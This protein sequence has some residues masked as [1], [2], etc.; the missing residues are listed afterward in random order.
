VALTGHQTPR[1]DAL[2]GLVS[3]RSSTKWMAC[4]ISV[5][6]LC[7]SLHA[8]TPQATALTS[9]D[10]ITFTGSVREV[11]T[12]PS[13]LSSVPSATLVRS[14]LAPAEA[15]ATLDFAIALKMHN[16][17]ELQE[18]T[19]AGQTISLDEIASKYYPTPV[20][21]KKVVDWLTGQ[22]F[23]VKQPNKYNLSVFAS[24]QVAQIERA[25]GAKFGRIKYA[26]VEY[27]SALTSPSLPVSVAAPVLGINGLQPHLHPV[28][29]LIQVAASQG[30][31]KAISNQPPY[32]VAEIAKAYGASGLN[33]NGAGQKIGIVIDTFPTNSDLTMFW[34]ANAIVQSLNNIEKVQVVPGTLP[35]TSGEESLDVEWSSGTAP[36]AK[37]RVYATT[38][39]AFVYLDEAYQA[40]IN[41]LP[42]QPGLRQ[43]SLSYGLGESYASPSQMQTDDQYFAALAGAG[44]TVFVSSGDGGSSPGTAGHDHT[45]PVQVE[46]PANDPNVTAVGGSSLNLNTSTGVV[47]SETGW[48][49]GGGGVST[50]FARPTWQTGPGVP[51]GSTR[52]VPDVA[53]VADPNTGGILFL[54]GNEYLVGGT[55]WSAPTWAGFCA[56]INQAR[57][58]LSRPAVGLLGSKIYP[59]IGTSNFRDITTGSNGP[60]GVY[61]AGPGYDLDTG[62]G[63]PNVANLIQALNGVTPNKHP[64][65]FNG[66][67]YDDLVW[68]NTVTGARNIWLIKNGVFSSSYSLGTVD[69]QWHI[70]GVGDFNGN[71]N[72]DLVW[73]NTT[74]GARTIWLLKNGVFSSSYS[75]GTVNAQWHIAGVGDFNG[76]GNADLVWENTTTGAHNIWILKNGVFSSSY[77]LGTIDPQ[78]HIAGVGDFN[79]DGNADLVWENTTTGGRNIWL[80]KNGVFSSSYSLGTVDP[81]WHIAGAGDFN[82]DGN[83]DL[84]WENT[85]TGARTI[86]LLKNG[87]FSSS[88]SLGTVDPQWHIK[89]H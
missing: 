45:G 2:L 82:G 62:I 88:Y 46:T 54:H 52:L 51:A 67:G 42:S 10:R 9:T 19:N 25:F 63:V 61:N 69:P 81:Q 27:T 4:I 36:G 31:Q 30:M 35:S 89:D 75:L 79:G 56:M 49:D 60:N 33:V 53:L 8:Q 23:V 14:E 12:I 18:R 22:G 84:V 39:L 17:T 48:Y 28:P 11:A 85:T 38:S 73:E 20:E 15:Q 57:A 34:N 1:S 86:W 13:Q 24:G 5:T 64:K 32:T 78:W 77:S 68:E 50:I 6:V 40:I 26:G 66:D 43:I 74:T 83:T 41:D 37:V 7:A 3:R 80:L 70:A 55:S 59:L 65:D 16:F 29:H 44:V 87:V 21:Y 58:N 76:D 47:S 71:G 72:A